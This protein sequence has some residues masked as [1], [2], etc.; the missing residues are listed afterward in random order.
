MSSLRYSLKLEEPLSPSETVVQRQLFDKSNINR[1]VVMV[2]DS[3]GELYSHG[4]VVDVMHEVFTQILGG[5]EGLGNSG[6]IVQRFNSAVVKK[7]LNRKM[8]SNKA[9]M[10]SR[11]VGFETN[12]I[13]ATMLPRAS[14]SLESEDEERGKVSY[15]FI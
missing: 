3:V 8:A 7:V 10:I 11:R 12:K 15:E 14:F 13:P 5:K 1:V 9:S 4:H 2:R 6:D